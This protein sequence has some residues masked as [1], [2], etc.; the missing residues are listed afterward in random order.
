LVPELA[1]KDWVPMALVEHDMA[2]VR[3]LADSVVV[4]G[5]SPENAE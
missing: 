1:A 2:F 3:N 4:L 5:R